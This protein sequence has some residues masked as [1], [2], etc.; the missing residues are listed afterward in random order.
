MG[1]FGRAG[2][3]IRSPDS[4]L[5]L[6]GSTH[7]FSPSILEVELQV[8]WA[9][10][11]YARLILGPPKIENDSTIVIGWIQSNTKYYTG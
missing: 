4:R 5:V 2:F 9:G 3:V 11:V 1:T 6:A 7:L 8:V 10:I